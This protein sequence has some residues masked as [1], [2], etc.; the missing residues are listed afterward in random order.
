MKSTLSILLKELRK[1]RDE[2]KANVEMWEKKKRQVSVC[3]DEMR[4]LHT[5]MHD[6]LGDDIDLVVWTDPSRMQAQGVRSSS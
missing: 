5:H 4:K 6:L 3:E 1:T 2:L